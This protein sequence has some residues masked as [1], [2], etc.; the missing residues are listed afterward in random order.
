MT[1]TL[2][3]VEI[4]SAL[5]RLVRDGALRERAARDAE[6]VTEELLAHAHVV[7]DVERVTGLARRLLRVHPLRAA[8]ALQLG[9]AILWADGHPG[10]L[11]MHTLDRRLGDAAGREGFRVVPAS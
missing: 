11:V 8:D 9:A 1:W 5:W 10:G 7:A 2:T 4:V 3:P 6:S